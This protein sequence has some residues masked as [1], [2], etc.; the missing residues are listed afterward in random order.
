MDMKKLC[1]IRVDP[2]KKLVYIQGGARWKD[3]NE[4]TQKHGLACVSSLVDTVG[5]AGYTLGGGFGYLTG[6]HAIM[7]FKYFILL[8]LLFFLFNRKTWIIDG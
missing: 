4:E 7:R 3:V 1:N 6:M 2:E 8:L 5:V